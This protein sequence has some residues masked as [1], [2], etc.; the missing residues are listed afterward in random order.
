MAKA[1]TAFP[2]DGVTG[3]VQGTDRTIGRDVGYAAAFRK[4]QKATPGDKT[5]RRTTQIVSQKAP[6][7]GGSAARHARSVTYCTCDKDYKTLDSQKL[8]KMNPW[9]RLITGDDNSSMS[10]YHIF[11]KICLKAM[12]EKSAFMRFSWCSRYVVKN[13]TGVQWTDKIVTFG[14]I[15]T[16][17]VDGQDVEVYLL[18][19]TTTK[20]GRITY[21]AKMI[22]FRLVHTVIIRGQA[23]VT[24]PTLQPGSSVLV[25]V[26]SY[27]K[28][29]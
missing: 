9:W 7:R 17:Q 23:L 25:D 8:M 15:P 29:V 10:A 18:L 3:T 11:M 26:Y 1:K 27:F 14:D 2:I 22:D 20:K 5:N 12:D 24:I 21:D 19:G 13:K 4:I 28:G 6:T 16:F